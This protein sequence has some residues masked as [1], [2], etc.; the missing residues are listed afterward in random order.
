MLFGGVVTLSP[1]NTETEL[2]M[3]DRV[4]VVLGDLWR[5]GEKGFKTEDCLT[6]T[7]QGLRGQEMVGVGLEGAGLAFGVNPGLG[8]VGPELGVP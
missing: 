3:E 5:E 1:F 6:L 4:E 7:S 8:M 2:G